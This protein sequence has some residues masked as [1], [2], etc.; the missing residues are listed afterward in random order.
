MEEKP[1]YVMPTVIQ[2][3]IV[4]LV[5][6][7]VSTIFVYISISG[8]PSGSF[9]QPVQLMQ[10]GICLISA[11]GGVLSV[12]AYLKTGAESITL[13]QGAVIG[14]LSAVVMAAVMSLMGAIW[15]FVIDPSLM[16]NMANHMMKNM[17][18]AFSNSGM[19]GAQVDETLAKIEESFA[20][21]KTLIGIIK[22]F[23]MSLIGLG[24][25][26]LLSGLITAKISSKD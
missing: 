7:I 1:S 5:L 6:S 20:E 8:E 23:G 22:G 2:S 24:I 12:K 13:G 15:N 25:I 26:N 18:M 17:E 3:T 14:L 19:S 4:A 9:F 21:Q 16:D 11:I 10:M